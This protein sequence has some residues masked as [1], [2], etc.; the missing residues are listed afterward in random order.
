M[1]GRH[2]VGTCL[3]N[4]TTSQ[5]FSGHRSLY[6]RRPAHRHGSGSPDGLLGST[7]SVVNVGSSPDP[8]PYL[9]NFGSRTTPRDSTTWTADLE[10]M[11]HFTAVT[12]S[13]LPRAQ[14]LQD[15]WQLELPKLAVTHG[16]LMHQLLAIAAFHMASLDSQR[17]N[18]R[19][20][21]ASQ[22]QGSAIQGL[23]S[24]LFAISD[25]NC[26]AAFA[27][28]TLL[29]ISAFAAFSENV[30]VQ[31]DIATDIDNLAE[32]CLLMRG[33]HGILKQH[34][35]AIARGSMG[36]ML[37][38]GTPTTQTTIPQSTTSVLAAAVEELRS[39]SMPPGVDPTVEMVCRDEALALVTW[40]GHAQ[41][42][43]GV[44]ELSTVMTWPLGVGDKFIG[45]MRGRNKAAL[46]VLKIY[47]C[48]LD[49]VGDDH[50]YLS[51]WGRSLLNDVRRSL[52]GL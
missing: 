37:Q 31:D 24:T 7:T 49:S 5:I 40:I 1:I 47:C 30:V 45:L 19:R 35:D 48:I 9:A 29:S 8:F 39:I 43:A 32:V 36:R 12:W 13:S 38:V 52:G 25:E 16:F 28:S 20:I 22:H 21:Q 33:M 42:R 11:H 4:V 26:H 15:I 34:E 51:G 18:E 6:P 41:A 46:S 27:T 3:R 10:L 2:Q 50:W 23:R 44:P 14:E 17:R